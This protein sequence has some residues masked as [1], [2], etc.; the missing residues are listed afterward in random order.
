MTSM[1]VQNTVVLDSGAHLSVAT[2]DVRNPFR[3]TSFL[4]FD[5]DRIQRDSVLKVGG[6]HIHEVLSRPMAIEG[7]HLVDFLVRLVNSDRVT[8]VAIRP[9]LDCCHQ[10][11]DALDLLRLSI[12][13][14][15]RVDAANF[16]AHTVAAAVVDVGK[17]EARVACNIFVPLVG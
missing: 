4:L 5:D 9:S 15:D 8:V 6:R 2:R 13:F 16:H 7:T 3:L 10:E 14:L 1:R 17:V 12:G 11:Q